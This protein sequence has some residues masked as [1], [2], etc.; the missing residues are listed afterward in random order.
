MKPFRLQDMHGGWFVG[1]F[2]P[3]C[4]KTPVAEVA[5]KIYQAGQSEPRH[6]HRVATEV[7]LVAYGRV[8]MNDRELSGGDIIV[9]NPGEDSSFEAIE[10]SA[11]VVVKLPSVAGDKYPI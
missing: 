8:R 3:T 6:V 2:L 9:L 7:T 4:L 5:Y 1:D 10:A 11:T